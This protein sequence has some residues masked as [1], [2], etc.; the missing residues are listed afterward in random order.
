M[1]YTCCSYM[2]S[3]LRLNY[4][5]INACCSMMPGPILCEDFSGKNINWEDIE[6]K[7]R[8]AIESCK[9]GVVPENC[10]GCIHLKELDWNENDKINEIFLLHYTHCNCSCVY[11][12]NQYITKS[13]VTRK[14]QKSEYYDAYPLL[15]EAYKKNR[16]SKNLTVHCLGGEPGVLKETDKIL[17]LFIK[18]GLRYV[19]CVTSGI[20]YVKRMEEVFKKYDGQVVISLDCATRETYKKIK[21][22]DKFDEVVKNIKKY[23][24]ASKGN[25]DRVMVK[26]ILTLGFN[27][28]IEEIDKFFD[29][30]TSLGLKQT[31]IDVD[32]KKTCDG[33]HD[34]LP[35]HFYDLYKYFKTQAELKNFDLHQYD[36]M[37]EIFRNNHY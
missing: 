5:S 15:K 19:Y 29:L 26:Y 6:Q 35:E 16:L 13:K 37:E 4:N 20:N 7:R 3:G 27:D 21:R 28:N 23:I 18:N 17:K 8:N 33:C 10:K 22:V 9:N 32:Y 14:V 1:K 31:R 11:C 30:L 12:V 25:P 34:K 36:V 2:H 24:K